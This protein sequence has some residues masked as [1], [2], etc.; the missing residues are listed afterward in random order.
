M[1]IVSYHDLVYIE[2][3]I[4]IPSGTSRH[5]PDPALTNLGF[6]QNQ[7]VGSDYRNLYIDPSSP[8]QIL[9]ISKDKYLSSQIYASAPAEHVHLNAATAFLQGLYPPLDEKT[10]SEP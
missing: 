10:A 9:G 6:Q 3:L 8:K 5:Y 2:V 7:Q 1:A 4:I